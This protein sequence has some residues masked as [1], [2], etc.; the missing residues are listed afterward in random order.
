MAVLFVQISVSIDGYIEDASGGLEWFTEDKA[1]EAFA[2]ETLRAIGGM[3]FGR[4]EERKFTSGALVSRY[5]VR[6][7]PA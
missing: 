2:T 6:N 3:V 1:V 5:A 4:I 7:S